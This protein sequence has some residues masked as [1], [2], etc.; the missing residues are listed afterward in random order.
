ME[1]HLTQLEMIRLEM[2]NLLAKLVYG[3]KHVLLFDS[4]AGRLK[5][6]QMETRIRELSE[7]ERSLLVQRN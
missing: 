2:D 7:Q 3:V 6:A 1:T 5:C 4:P